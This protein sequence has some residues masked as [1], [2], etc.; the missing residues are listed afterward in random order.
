MDI[1]EPIISSRAELLGLQQATHLTFYRNCSWRRRCEWQHPLRRW[2]SQHEATQHTIALASMPLCN[3]RS[4]DCFPIQETNIPQRISNVFQRNSTSIRFAKVVDL[5][6]RVPVAPPIISPATPKSAPPTIARPMLAPP[7]VSEIVSPS[8]NSSAFSTSENLKLS[9]LPK[10]DAI[11]EVDKAHFAIN[12]NGPFSVEA[13]SDISAA[14]PLVSKKFLPSRWNCDFT[15]IAAAACRATNAIVIHKTASRGTAAR[16]AA[17]SRPQIGLRR[18][19]RTLRRAVSNKATH[20]WSANSD[21]K[22]PLEL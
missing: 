12:D 18:G 6:L 3:A 5:V 21:V 10:W 17:V 9:N 11:V 8:S 1:D 20:T 15:F 22:D 14:C 19:C 16:P 7:P 2:L 4:I 13:W